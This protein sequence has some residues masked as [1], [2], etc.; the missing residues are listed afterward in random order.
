MDN[1]EE[2]DYTIDFEAVKQ[3]TMTFFDGTVKT[4]MDPSDISQ[5]LL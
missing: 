2:P 5:T 1:D 4:F 3:I